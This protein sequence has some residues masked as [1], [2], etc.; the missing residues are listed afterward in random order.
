MVLVVVEVVV[1][2]GGDGG[3]GGGGGCVGGGNRGSHGGRV[4]ELTLLEDSLI[5]LTVVMVVAIIDIGKNPERQ[6]PWLL[7]IIAHW[8][9]A[10]LGGSVLS[11]TG[12]QRPGDCRTGQGGSRI[13]RLYQGPKLLVWVLV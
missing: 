2:G 10:P 6:R 5:S 12:H 11:L 13:Q 4:E 1:I 7:C 8:I 9:S 3:G